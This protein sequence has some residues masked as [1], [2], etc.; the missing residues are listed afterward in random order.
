ANS[1]LAIL[2]ISSAFMLIG[3][4]IYDRFPS[5]WMIQI[6]FIPDVI[7]FVFGPA[8][9]LFL[10]RLFSLKKHERAYLHWLPAII[11]SLMICYF[12]TLGSTLFDQLIASQKIWRLIFY[13]E[14]LGIISN[15]SYSILSVRL[16]VK[17]SPTFKSSLS[18]NAPIF[19][20]VKYYLSGL[21]L[22]EILWLFGYLSSY[23]LK[24][25]SPIANYVTV[26]YSLPFISYLVGY[27]L[28]VK[29]PVLLWNI[30]KEKKV[31]NRLNENVIAQLT[32]RLNKAIYVDHIYRRDNLT[33]KDLA[34]R[35]ET[36]VHNL[37]WL[38]NEIHGQSFYD[39]INAIRVKEFVSKIDEDQ[40]R[41]KTILGLAIE[42]GFKS[43]STFNKAFKSFYQT[44]PSEFIRKNDLA[45]DSKMINPKNRAANKILATPPLQT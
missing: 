25:P 4:M 22:C 13:I 43:K 40:H 21:F 44:T 38:L 24:T 30:E 18:F 28:V 12:F 3:R 5:G 26:W 10:R 9:F 33:L 14:T 16:V 36:S 7:I 42:V 15:L 1:A 31:T 39:F 34:D 11:Y 8:S 45:R 23:F 17:Y 37:S 6:A 41:K 20:F 27:Y 29:P 35:V 19:N 32:T 2:L